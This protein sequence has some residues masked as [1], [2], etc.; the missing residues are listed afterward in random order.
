MI[1][2]DHHTVSQHTDCRRMQDTGRKQIQ[3]KFSLIR[4]YRMPGIIASLI[5]DNIVR[6]FCEKIHDSSL[7]FIAPV[8]SSH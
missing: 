2:I 3:H 8:N 7:S 6:L 4:H 1:R 5:T